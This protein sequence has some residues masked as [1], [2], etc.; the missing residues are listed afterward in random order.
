M[1]G[2]H[3]MGGMHGFGPVDRDDSAPYH[4][5][6]EIRVRAMVN[7]CA[8]RGYVP[9][10]DM[11][12]R[13]IEEMPPARY[14]RSTYFERW[15]YAAEQVLIERGILTRAELDARCVDLSPETVPQPAPAPRFEYAQ[16]PPEGDATHAIQRF[17]VGDR[18]RVRNAHPETHTRAPRYV[19][20][21]IGVIHRCHGH[22]IFP[23]SNSEYLADQPQVVYSV[24]FEGTAIWG[25]SAEPAT[26]LSIDLWDSYLDPA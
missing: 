21:K 17:D 8:A 23:D 4:D 5:D 9:S 18:V 15:E 24:Q 13:A 20:D 7:L 12:R 19:R 25:P 6:W 2:V 10:Y 16:A 14:L 22:E 3:D 11:F 1:N 26:R